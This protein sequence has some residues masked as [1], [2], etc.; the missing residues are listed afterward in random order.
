MDDDTMHI[1]QGEFPKTSLGIR[2]VRFDGTEVEAMMEDGSRRPIH[3]PKGWRVQAL[4]S[5]LVFQCPCGEFVLG[6]PYHECR[7]KS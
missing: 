7:E 4:H 3:I 2:A 1:R 5:A 6:A